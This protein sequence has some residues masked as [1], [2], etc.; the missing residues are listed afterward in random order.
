MFSFSNATAHMRMV[1]IF[2]S[3]FGLLADSRPLDPIPESDLNDWMNAHQ[4]AHNYAN[5]VLGLEGNDLSVVNFNNP[6]E[7]AAWTWLHWQEHRNFSQVLGI[8]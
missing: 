5:A 1:E 2:F 7:L 3:A 6:E 4:L 8:Q